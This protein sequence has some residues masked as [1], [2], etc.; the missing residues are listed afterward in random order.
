M[1]KV[2]KRI[3][4]LL[5]GI[6]E[7]EPAKLTILPGKIEVECE[8]DA[9]VHGSFRIEGA[10][11]RKVRGFLYS[12]SP[13][14]ICN[15]SEFQGITNDIHYQIDCSGLREGMEESGVLTICSDH[16][17]ETIPYSFRIAGQEQEAVTASV[18]SLAEL[19]DLARDNFQ[20]AYR[21]FLSAPFR[22]FLKDQ[23]PLWLGLYDSFGIPS[24]QYQS[25]EEFLV[26][27]G[28]KDAIELS[29]SAD[30]LERENLTE[31][32]RET[33]Q[34]VRST[35]GFQKITVTSDAEFLRPV[36]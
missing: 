35:W 32:V 6:F 3:E 29:V 10:D 18:N 23:E 20:K 22:Q 19:A 4:Q 30:K 5:N 34:I 25:L 15:P 13:R 14:I 27:T 17:E 16:G 8:P 28:Q 26:D 31:P 11:G 2:K 9:V 33:I 36:K 24:Y 21:V 12:P 7:Y 1:S